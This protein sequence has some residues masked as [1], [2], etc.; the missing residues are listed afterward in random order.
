MPTCTAG[1]HTLSH[2][3]TDL[4]EGA[5][6]TVRAFINAASVREIVFTSGTTE[7]INLVAYSFGQRPEPAVTR[8]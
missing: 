7:A 5:R 8:S 2:R 1:V 6:E 4:Y 3:A